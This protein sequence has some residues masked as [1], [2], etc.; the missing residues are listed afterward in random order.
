MRWMP[1]IPRFD[2]HK[3]CAAVKLIALTVLMSPA[4]LLALGWVLRAMKA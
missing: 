1:P 3:N 2:F 4:I